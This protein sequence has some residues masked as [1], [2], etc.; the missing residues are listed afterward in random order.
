M[1]P[2]DCIRLSRTWDRTK[3]RKIVRDL[4]GGK[5]VGKWDQGKALE[6]ASRAA[7]DAE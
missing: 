7:V 5:S 4:K 6:Y 3:L 2:E 1:K